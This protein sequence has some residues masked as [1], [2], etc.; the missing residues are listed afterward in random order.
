MRGIRQQMSSP[1]LNSQRSSQLHEVKWP[2]ADE[3]RALIQDFSIVVGGPVYDFLLRIG[4]LRL[5]LPNV[6]RRIAVL[7]ALTWLPLLLFSLIDG[8]ALGSRVKIPLL[9]DY[10]MYGRFLLALPLLLLAEVG[11]DPAIRVAVKA[12]VDERIVQES[13]LADFEAVLR[14]TQRLRDAVLP[15][16]LLLLLAFF[17]I[18]VF[19]HEWQQGAVAT[20]HS[21]AA[22]LTRAGW[23][24]ASV[25]TPLLRFVIYRW[26]FRYVVWIALQWRI[27]RLPLHL[28]PT[29][30][31]HAAG[32]YF[33]S[34]PQLR[35]GVLFCAL[36]CSFAGQ[37]LNTVTHE[38]ASLASFK[39]LMI[40]FVGIAVMLN[41][42]PLLLWAPKLI[43][44]RRKGLREYA[45]LGNRYTEEFDRKW[46][47]FSVPAAEPLLGT[48][49]IQSMADLANSYAVILDMS[50]VPI[51][52][53]L[54]VQLAII[55]GAPLIPVVIAVT[56]IND[57]VNTVFKM[58]A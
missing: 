28:L 45:A 44:V 29:H 27:S 4:L 5:G 35:F 37:I 11:I 53:R 34:F 24:Y 43:K 2:A 10:A 22:G 18:F 51:S 19:R 7:V 33:L 39:L 52:K 21:T 32:L 12:F 25:S 15:E 50:I 46:V 9:L 17:P 55:A 56:P 38:G 58:V 49:D 40:A 31:D 48:S 14:R 57:V 42:C 1:D 30:P 23:W 26:A 6:L 41:L 3:T 8:V 47:H 13:D 36:G 54:I 20:W 16:L